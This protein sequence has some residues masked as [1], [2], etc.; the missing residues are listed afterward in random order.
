[1]RNRRRPGDHV[2]LGPVL[3]AVVATD[4]QHHHR[5]RRVG[6]GRDEEDAPQMVVDDEDVLRRLAAV[7]VRQGDH[8]RGDDRAADQGDEQAAGRE[9]LLAGHGTVEQPAE[10]HESDHAEEHGRV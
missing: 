4:G 5:H 3:D 7:A 1:M 8:V 6:D 10:R 9:Q 2:E